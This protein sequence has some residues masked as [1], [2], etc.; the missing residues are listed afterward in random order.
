MSGLNCLDFTGEDCTLCIPSKAR[1]NCTDICPVL[2]ANGATC[3]VKTRKC[4]CTSGWTGGACQEPCPPGR[5]GQNCLGLCECLLGPCD[6]LT[7]RCLCDPNAPIGPDCSAPCDCLVDGVCRTQANCPSGRH[8]AKHTAEQMFL[9]RKKLVVHR[10]NN[11]NFMEYW[12]VP[13]SAQQDISVLSF[14]L[15]MLTCFI[16]FGPGTSVFDRNTILSYQLSTNQ[17]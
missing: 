14:F 7:G 2:C 6:P 1:R 9:L 16:K 5:F 12:Q 13:F 10:R 11:V 17:K 8:R 3:N 15:C 4:E